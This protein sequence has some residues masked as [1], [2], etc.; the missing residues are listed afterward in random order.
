MYLQFCFWPSNADAFVVQGVTENT[1]WADSNAVSS[2]NHHNHNS[3]GRVRL[4]QEITVLAGG[5][6]SGSSTK[7]TMRHMT[8]LQT[9]GLKTVCH[10]SSFVNT[11]SSQLSLKETS[12]RKK[13]FNNAISP[14]N[15]FA[16]VCWKSTPLWMPYG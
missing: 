5:I 12:H 15:T 8:P 9:C 6:G 1:V 13:A 3:S 16:V 7:A 11:I 2:S 14:K 4:F 10:H